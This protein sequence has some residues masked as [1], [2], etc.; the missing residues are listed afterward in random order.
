MGPHY[1][2]LF[3]GLILYITRGL[4]GISSPCAHSPD[5]PCRLSL[6]NL[7]CAKPLCSY[8]QPPRLQP[9][10]A[11]AP[12]GYGDQYRSLTYRP[13][14]PHTIVW[15]SMVLSL[16]TIAHI[17]IVFHQLCY[18]HRYIISTG[19][20]ATRNRRITC[21]RPM[22]PLSQPAAAGLA[23]NQLPSLLL[24][25]RRCPSSRAR[26]RWWPGPETPGAAWHAAAPGAAGTTSMTQHTGQGQRWRQ[27]GCLT[28]SGLMHGEH[29]GP[30]QAWGL[31]MLIQ[32]GIRA[33]SSTD[34]RTQNHRC[35]VPRGSPAA[36]ARP[37]SPACRRSCPPGPEERRPRPPPPRRA[38]AAGRPSRRSSRPGP[39]DPP[40]DHHNQELSR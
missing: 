17:I 29:V 16:S 6:V 21:H 4:A 1:S 33:P 39:S 40:D 38:S 24:M 12:L 26:R 34:H 27:S 28:T 11:T 19:D 20:A 13:Y 22:P 23:I 3:L 32:Q 5:A 35:M 25:Q 10:P 37:A 18:Y 2:P 36:H 14:V 8:Y 15:C 31:L 7:C 9:K 30:S